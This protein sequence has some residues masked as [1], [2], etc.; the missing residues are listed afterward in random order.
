MKTKTKAYAFFII[1]TLAIGG[2]SALLTKDNMNIYDKIN[3]PSF[4]PPA[5]VFPIAW[6]ILYVLMGIGAACVYLKGREDGVYTLPALGLYFA[7]LA[8]NFFWS[9]IFF[10]LQNFLFSFLWLL[11]LLVLVCAMTIKFYGIC[12]IGALIQIP[13]ILWLIF[14]AVLNYAIFIINV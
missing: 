5:I 9:I 1:F 11:L 3:T 7:Q 2:L 13:Y 10:N 14:A 8:V 6:G 4:A 12:K